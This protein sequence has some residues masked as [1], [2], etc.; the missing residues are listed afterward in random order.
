MSR[1]RGGS[2]RSSR[3]R[4][5]AGSRRWRKLRAAQRQAETRHR[6]RVRLA[7]HHAAKALV[8]WAVANRVGTLVVGDPAGITRRD[9]GPVQNWRLRQWRRTHLIGCL[10]DKAEVAGIRI[11]RVDER[12][13][14]STCPACH[15][16][17]PKPRGRTLHCPG[18]GFTGHRDLAGALNIAA[19][20]GGGDTPAPTRGTGVAR[21]HSE[22]HTSHANRRKTCVTEH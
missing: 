1:K 20:H 19:E 8:G 16:R 17:V 11:V 10:T 13:T 22:D 6:R 2:G 15:A 7:H 3:G 5:Q 4:F 9:A 12:G 21:T 14:S 18:C